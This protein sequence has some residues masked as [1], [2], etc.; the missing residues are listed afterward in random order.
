MPP[1]PEFKPQS[2]L[3]LGERS[4]VSTPEASRSC[5]AFLERAS[6]GASQWRTVMMEGSDFARTSLK[7]QGLPEALGEVE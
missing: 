1:D 4:R 5:L 3:G 7:A 6:S 2:F